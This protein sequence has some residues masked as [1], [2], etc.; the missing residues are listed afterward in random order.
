MFVALA[1]DKNQGIVDHNYD[2]QQ[3]NDQHFFNGKYLWKIS[4]FKKICLLLEQSDWYAW[5]LWRKKFIPKLGPRR[6]IIQQTNQRNPGG[7]CSL[8]N[9]QRVDILDMLK[10]NK[11]EINRLKM[12]SQKGKIRLSRKR[13]RS[14]IRRSPRSRS[15]RKRNSSQGRMTKSSRKRSRSPRRQSNKRPK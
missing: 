4:R 11:V 14:P 1:L 5:V 3:K 8:C 13:S 6:Q 15:L 9:L 2:Q 7:I 10:K 12:R